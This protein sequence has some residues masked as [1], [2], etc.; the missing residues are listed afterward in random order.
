MLKKNLLMKMLLVLFISTGIMMLSSC[1]PDDSLSYGETDIVMV[2]YYDSVNF[3]TLKT[4]YMSDTVHVLR[5]DTTDHSLVEYNNDI[6]AAIATNMATFGYER[7]YDTVGGLPDVQVATSAI[8]VQ[9]VSV[10]YPY[11][12]YWGWGWGWGWYKSSPRGTDY[13]YPGYPGYYPPG[14]GWGYPYYTSYTTG[15]LLIEM[16]NPADYRVVDNDTVTPIYWNAGMNGVLSSGSDKN[17][18]I[19]LIDKSF[20]L[21]PQI[22]TN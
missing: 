21:S 13:Y 18:I 15:T 19:E 22:K 3:T 5:D 12:P 1:Y 6:I 20:E 11:Y 10:Y 4:Y 7:V 14:Y 8:T 2:G 17:R 16:A 9:N